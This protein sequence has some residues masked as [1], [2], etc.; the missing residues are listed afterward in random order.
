MEVGT[1]AVRQLCTRVKNCRPLC[2]AR[3]MSNLKKLKRWDY[4]ADHA[5][6][7]WLPWSAARRCGKMLGGLGKV[8]RREMAIAGIA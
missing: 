8:F 6:H 4:Y 7:A 5:L 2:G 3:V 1:G